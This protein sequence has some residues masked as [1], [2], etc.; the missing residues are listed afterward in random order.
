MSIFNSSDFHNEASVDLD[1]LD[2]RYMN[3]ESDTINHLNIKTIQLYDTASLIFKDNTIQTTAFN[4]ETIEKIY[5]EVN[6]MIDNNTGS[7][8]NNENTFTE[9][10]IFDNDVSINN[11]LKINDS[12]NGNSFTS[13][14]HV[15]NLLTVNCAN[16]NGAI[17]FNRNGSTIMRLNPNNINFYN[18]QLLNVSSIKYK[19]LTEQFSAFTDEYIA[20]IVTSKKQTK[21]LDYIFIPEIPNIMPEYE[22]LFIK[23]DTTIEGNVTIDGNINNSTISTIQ[24]NINTIKTDITDIKTDITD[25]NTLLSSDNNAIT[26]SFIINGSSLV[27]PSKDFDLNNNDIKNVNTYEIGTSPSLGYIVMNA[28]DNVEIKGSLDQDIILTTNASNSSGYSPGPHNLIIS[29]PEIDLGDRTI[30][31]CPTIDNIYTSINLKASYAK[32]R[33]T[34]NSSNNYI[35]DWHSTNLRKFVNSNIYISK[36]STGLITLMLDIPENG[37]P[38]DDHFVV[39]GNG[40]QYANAD[41]GPRRG[42]YFTVIYKSAVYSSGIFKGH[43]VQLQLTR[44]EGIDEVYDLIYHNSTHQGWLDVFIAW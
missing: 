1:V 14:S 32:C 25:I 43:T 41:V 2:E 34:V 33:I 35:Y 31:N 19:D 39:T 36:Q 17:S 40:R 27:L 42:I 21:K 11:Q 9:K 8:T 3:Q 44:T 6:N 12:N 29:T 22:Q 26:E 24:S 7:I 15:G 38:V 23:T 28:N 13:I 4:T 10:N 16:T 18:K 37:G 30:L 5:L 20:D